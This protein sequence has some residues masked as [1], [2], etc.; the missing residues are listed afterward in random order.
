MALSPGAAGGPGRTAASGTVHRAVPFA[1]TGH[2]AE[3]LSVPLRA[4]LERGDRI[5]AVVDRD[6]RAELDRTL[7]PDA[8][9]EFRTPE[10]VHNAPPFTV[11][12]RWARAA[13]EATARDGTRMTT[14]GQ[15]I[16]GL[17]GTDP[18][19]WVRLDVALNQVLDGMPVTMLCAFPDGEA[20]RDDAATLHDALLVDGEE[21]P[22]TTR[23]D[24]R[25]LL[26]EHPQ[27][28]P[29]DL[30]TPL[31]EIDVDLAG[32][33][34]LRRFV[35]AE[36]RLSGLGPSRTSDLVLAL[37][38]V[39]TNGVEHGSGLPRLRMWRGPDGLTGEVV[40]TGRTRLPFPGMLAPTS[41]G[42]RGRGLWLASE[43]TDVLQVWTADDDPGCPA[44]TV[45]RVLMTPP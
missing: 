22:S 24:P 42:V 17:P 20:A 6:C 27:R 41:A 34:T 36:A 40:D 16:D 5:L 13:R 15:L 4:T 39:A 23:R 19:Y 38:E 28:P 21:V 18:G 44:G 9:I 29:A 11:A 12:T 26:A 7:G 14:V 25:D 3:V 2:Q 45:V 43:L 32:L 30:G 10:H 1:D 31:F 35:R 33:A 37:N 8:G